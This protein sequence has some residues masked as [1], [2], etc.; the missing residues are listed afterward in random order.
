MAYWLLKSDADSYSFSDL[1]K[2]GSTAW[3]GVRNRQARNNIAAMQIGDLA[4]IYHSVTEKQIV[5]LAEI[6]SEPFHDSTIDDPVWLAVQIKANDRLKN[7]V[8]LSKI[9]SNPELS[10]L[11]LIKQSRLSVMPISDEEFKIIMQMSEK[12]D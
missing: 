5:G 12:N 1:E 7:P 10:N 3:D 6:I 2:D 8:S 4:L 11:P 9:K